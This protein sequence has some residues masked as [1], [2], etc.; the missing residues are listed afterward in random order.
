MHW[1][2]GLRSPDTDADDKQPDQLGPLRWTIRRA[3]EL[4]DEGIDLAGDQLIR[5]AGIWGDSHA[6]KTPADAA[7]VRRRGRRDPAD[8]H[9]PPLE[10][11]IY[12]TPGGPELP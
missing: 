3:I 9:G 11:E 6:E 8:D 10:H 5:S 7:E 12:N 4:V 2:F 1:S